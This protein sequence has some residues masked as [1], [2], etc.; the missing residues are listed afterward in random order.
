MD[1]PLVV[2]TGASSGIGAAAARALSGEGYPLLLTARRIDRLHEL[3]LPHCLCR[4]NDVADIEGF[5][6][7]VSDAETEYGPVDLLI[8][9]AGAMTLEQFRNQVPE[10]WKKLF[11]TN[12]VGL[13]NTTSV[14]FPGMLDRK[15]GTI[16]NIGSTSG[17]THYPNHTVYGGTKHAIRGMTEGLRREAAPRGVRVMMISPGMVDTELLG[18]TR[19]ETI[20]DEYESFKRYLDGGVAPDE[21]AKA[22]LF[23]YQQRQ[24]VA[25]WDMIIA[26]TGQRA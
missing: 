15:G 5:R 26:P 12:V 18:G 25:I 10:D 1:K 16:L 6:R 7:A 2:I 13:L 14:I 21:V 9:N 19:N 23:A 8:N 17:Y 20:V 11:D 3:G 24:E 22:I 4:Q